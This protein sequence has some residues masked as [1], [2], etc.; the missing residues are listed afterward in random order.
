LRGIVILSIVQEAKVDTEH[1]HAIGTGFFLCDQSAVNGISD[2]EVEVRVF[3][4]REELLSRSLMKTVDAIREL[5]S[6]DLAGA[7]SPELT[8][9]VREL[10]GELTFVGHAAELAE[11]TTLR[12]C[13]LTVGF[14]PSIPNSP[15]VVLCGGR[16][17]YSHMLDRS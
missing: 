6:I 15:N 8:L 3:I 2:R 12:L 17:R 1:L 4:L 14:H 11:P 5:V 7:P 13:E 10:S 9:E 16:A